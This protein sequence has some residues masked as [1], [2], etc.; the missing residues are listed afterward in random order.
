M[1]TRKPSLRRMLLGM[2]R[3]VLERKR[4]LCKQPAR[5]GDVRGK[6]RQPAFFSEA[7]NC[8]DAHWR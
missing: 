8:K 2:D 5:V 3:H 7:N 1:T 6:E 4:C